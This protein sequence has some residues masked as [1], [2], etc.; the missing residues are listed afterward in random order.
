MVSTEFPEY[1]VDLT[2]LIRSDDRPDG[3]G[4]KEVVVNAHGEG[5]YSGRRQETGCGSYARV[6]HTK[7][8]AAVRSFTLQVWI[9]PTRPLCHE[10]QGLV[11]KWNPIRNTGYGL[12]VEPEGDLSL[13][14][15]DSMN[16]EVLRTGIPL[17]PCTWY[18]AA[19]TFDAGS[20]HAQVRQGPPIDWR[21]ESRTRSTV[22]EYLRIRGDFGTD[23]PLLIGAA[24]LEGAMHSRAIAHC[25]YNGKIS[26]PCLFAE[27][28]SNKELSRI[29]RGTAPANIEARELLALWDFASD[30]HSVRVRDVSGNGHDCELINMPTRGVTGHN[31]RRREVAFDHA[32]AEYNAVH[33]HDDDIED[34][35][36]EP[37]IELHVPE[38]ARSGF[39][40]ARL[41]VPGTGV[42]DHVPFI[43]TPKSDDRSA[44]IAVLAPTMTYLAYA[45]ERQLWTREDPE[46]RAHQLD[47]LLAAHPEYGMSLYDLHSDGSP[48]YYSSRLRPIPNM[49][50][51]YRNWFTKAPANMA[52]D[53]AIVDWLENKGYG[54][55]V[56]TDEQLHQ[57]GAPLLSRYRVV[58]TGTHPEYAT[59]SMLDALDSY[60]QGGGRLMYL[61]GNGLYWVTSVDPA[62]PHVIEVR[63]GMN[64]T[65]SYTS[66]P[67]EG[68]HSTTGEQGGLWRYRGRPPNQLL[69]VGFAAMTR[70]PRAAGFR[71]LQESYNEKYVPLFKGV[72]KEIIGDFGLT[73][74][75]AAGHEIDKFDV[76]C[77]SPGYAVRLATSAGEHDDD[78][79]LATEEVLATAPALGGSTNPD[80]R[81]DLTLVEWPTGGATFSVGSMTWCASLSHEGYKNDVSKIT[82]NVLR[83]FLL[84]KTDHRG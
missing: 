37:D 84:M 24:Y 60:L 14:I 27:A 63:R 21:A 40:A 17:N 9:Y 50:P 58:L 20:G 26:A 81:A 55:A 25:L 61:G 35:G 80:V 3:S 33:F 46:S 10:R 72:K 83:R 32:P 78:Y 68:F 4:F 82:E 36:W 62:K 79:Q 6:V 67:G 1:C 51:R 47:R 38:N 31:W 74:G 11:A 49:R 22:E 13:R 34:A 39:Y 30:Q 70:K 54:Y 69:G 76:S 59:G 73:L 44:D 65:R 75:G 8:L 71:R 48:C 7:A 66:P 29:L 52:A 23:A 28:L 57:E 43:V 53:L 64:G 56:L 16:L 42:V 18:F 5:V 19:C 15:S 41:S 2:R 45:N 77:G 12:F